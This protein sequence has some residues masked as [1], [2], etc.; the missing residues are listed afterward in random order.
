MN[1]RLAIIFFDENETF[2]A[3]SLKME[4]PFA[5]L[6]SGFAKRETPFASW[7][8][9]LSKWPAL[10]ARWE[11]P[12]TSWSS[13]PARLPPP[14]AKREPLLGNMAALACNLAAVPRKTGTAPRQHAYTA[15]KIAT[16]PRKTGTALRQHA[17]IA[18]KIATAPRKTGAVFRQH[19]CIAGKIATTPRKTGAV[20]RQPG[21]CLRKMGSAFRGL[22]WRDPP[23]RTSVLTPTCSSPITWDE[24][25][26]AISHQHSGLSQASMVG[27]TLFRRGRRTEDTLATSVWGRGASFTNEARIRFSRQLNRRNHHAPTKSNCLRRI[28]VT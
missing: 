1:R 9:P 2:F 6:P 14:L 5:T 18:G 16:A 17:C 10:P 15:S 24:V 21:H 19:A 22:A 20:F 26:R 25:S 7:S 8:I 23:G 4:T 28:C 27:V 12:L 11:R 13:L 3:M